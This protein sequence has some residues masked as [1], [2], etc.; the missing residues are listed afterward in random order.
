MTVLRS[1]RVLLPAGVEPAAI[2]IE[3]GKITQVRTYDNLPG[4]LDVV[5]CKDHVIMPGL[6]DPHVHINDPGRTDWED[7]ETATRAAAAGGVTTLVDM[8][9]NCI[10]ATTTLTA[11]KA[12]LAAA[13]GRCWTN[14]RL[15][16]GV[17]PGNTAE[18]RP[19]WEAGVSGFK[20]F[21]VPSGVDEFP[22]VTEANLREAMPMLT[23]LG[24][25]LL[26]HAE[27]PE[28]I[29]LA[30][31]DPNTDNTRYVNYLRTRPS[32]AEIEAIELMIRLCQEYR[33]R[34]HIVHLSAA[35]AVPI[36]RAARA[37][38][39]PLTVETCPHYLHF[40]A[41]EIP[42]YSTHF[43]CAPPIRV[44]E[45]REGLWHALEAGVIDFIATDH[46]PC[47][48]EMK[49]TTEGDFLRAWGGIATLGLALPVVWTALRRRG[50]NA[51]PAAQ[52]LGLRKI[53]QW[54]SKRPA[55]F[56]GLAGEIGQIAPG[57]AADLVVW[58][59]ESQREWTGY[60][61]MTPYAGEV[62]Y[63]VVHRTYLR[64]KLIFQKN[65]DDGEYSARPEGHC[66]LHRSD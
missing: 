32:Q 7:F 51:N 25:P 20:C 45:N 29:E 9:L 14:V 47:P 39:L 26:V 21:L 46:S 36:L 30:K 33:T 56:I 13:N 16:G 19:M 8:P 15:W 11:L 40:A 28:Q 23:M 27:D 60:H 50:Y 49:L 3:N 17:V 22:A 37:K 38:G 24:A 54:M 57:S 53:V 35:G 55:G 31:P 61:K 2:V 1:T 18:L 34:V 12:K 62:L 63:G 5:D 48:E 59:P 58:D 44:A 66:E 10:P 41:E 65:G 4:G 52:K 42:D 64:G 43:K 6:V